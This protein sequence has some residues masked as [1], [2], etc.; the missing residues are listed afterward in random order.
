MQIHCHR[1]MGKGEGGGWHQKIK[2][3][4]AIAFAPELEED[5]AHN[6]QLFHVKKLVGALERE[7]LQQVPGTQ[8]LRL[9]IP[10][11]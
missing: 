2:R 11:T 9:F 5:I 7:G 3:N 8:P 4:Q 6:L 10:K 1:A